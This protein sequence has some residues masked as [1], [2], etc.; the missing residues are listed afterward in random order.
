MSPLSNKS[1][2]NIKLVEYV[3]DEKNESGTFFNALSSRLYY[4]VFQKAKALLL[5]RKFDYK[6][7]LKEIKKDKDREFSHGTIKFAIKNVL[8]KENISN[9]EINKYLS[10][11]DNIYRSRRKADYETVFITENEFMENYEYSKNILDFLDEKIIVEI[12]KK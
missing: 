8:L 1:D 11:W 12:R 4:S 2:E 3:L 10:H 5:N 9:D 7:F 6:A